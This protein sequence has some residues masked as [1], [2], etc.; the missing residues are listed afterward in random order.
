VLIV[1][2]GQDLA[3][4]VLEQ[5]RLLTNLETPTQK[6]LQV[7]LIGQPELIRLLDREE[8]RQL[9]QRVTARYHLL[10]FS[11]DDTRAYIVH[12]IQIAGQKKKIFTDAA[13]RAVHKAAR[14]I[15][16]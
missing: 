14:G 10:P 16:G 8:L 3:T 6:L 12:R 15:R 1:D 11:E 5:I 9:A 7:I 2:E 13:M 4:D